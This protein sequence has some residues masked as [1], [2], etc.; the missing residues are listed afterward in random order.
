VRLVTSLVGCFYGLAG[1]GSLVPFILFILYGP[2]ITLDMIGL[3]VLI[4]YTFPLLNSIVC[5]VIAYGGQ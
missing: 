4:W 3:P 5:F 2:P 1:L